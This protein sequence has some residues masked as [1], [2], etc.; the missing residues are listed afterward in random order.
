[1]HCSRLRDTGDDL[2]ADVEVNRVYGVVVD[3]SAELPER[4]SLVRAEDSDE[5]S[6]LGGGGEQGAAEVELE[7]FDR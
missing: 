6:F 5:G 7:A 3:A 1:M 4:L 2:V